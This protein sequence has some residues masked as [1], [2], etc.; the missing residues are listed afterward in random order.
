MTV[1]Q[2]WRR[3]L[4]NKAIFRQLNKFYDRFNQRLISS[5]V[6]LVIYYSYAVI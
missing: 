6:L 4:Q 5:V 2:Q 3:I 1:Q